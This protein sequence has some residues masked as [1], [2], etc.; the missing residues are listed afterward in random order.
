MRICRY[1]T[2]VTGSKADGDEVIVVVS[3]PTSLV[4][5]VEL[6]DSSDF[7]KKADTSFRS[8]IATALLRGVPTK[9]INS[10]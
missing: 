7:T 8:S 1:R 5:G 3:V 4:V 9:S 10:R 6:L 2:L